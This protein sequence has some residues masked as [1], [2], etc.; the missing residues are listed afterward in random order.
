MEAIGR[1]R[2]A[3]AEGYI[4]SQSSFTDPR[5]DLARDRLHPQRR[6]CDGACAH[7]RLLRRSRA[8][9]AL[10]G[11]GRAAAHAASALQRS[12]RPGADPARHRLFVGV[13][14][15][16]ADRGAAHPAGFPPRRSQPAFDDRLRRARERRSHLRLPARPIVASIALPQ[17]AAAHDRR[18]SRSQLREPSTASCEL[19]MHRTESEDAAS[20]CRRRFQPRRARQKPTSRSPAD[21]PRR[22]CRWSAIP[23]RSGSAP[24]ARP[25]TRRRPRL[26]AE[27]EALGHRRARD[28]RH[29]GA[30]LSRLLRRLRQFGTVAGAAFA[31]RSHP[32]HRRRL[33]LLSRR[34]R[35]H[36]AGT[37]ALLRRRTRSSGSTI[38][39][40]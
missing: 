10:F 18:T 5:P 22:F 31:P 19:S 33:R 24:A 11:H 7:H 36:G 39:I 28:R 21:W 3:I 37:A 32:R 35:L 27:T 13:R 14:I 8:G 30:A 1:T 40:S 12:Q 4:P 34:Q 25:E 6:R 2:W 23:A 16:R 29:A 26:F 9:R 20:E 17:V 38:I 15:R